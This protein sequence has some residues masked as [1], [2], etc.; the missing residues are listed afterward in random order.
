MKKIAIATLIALSAA[1]AAAVEVGIT[2]VQEQAMGG[3]T[4]LGL[5][6]GQSFGKLTATGGVERF[7][8]AANNQ[9]RYSVGASYDITTVGPV[10]IAATAG[11]AYLQ[12]SVGESGY[13]LTAGL[14]A[15]LPLTKSV[16]LTVD[17]RLQQG[18][19]RVTAYDGNGV[20][21]GIKVAF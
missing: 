13:A 8:S 4:G 3:R 1:A 15:R 19:T 5:T 11:G 10:T 20:S 9:D 2:S 18:Q 7:T 14:G 6:V 16:S 17:Y 12:N 21:A